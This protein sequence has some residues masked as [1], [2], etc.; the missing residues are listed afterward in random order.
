MRKI[1][2]KIIEDI[3]WICFRFYFDQRDEW[4]RKTT[5]KCFEII[6]KYKLITIK[7][8]GFNNFNEI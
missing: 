4:N 2:E 8:N 1:N 7:P 6:N 3:N 5:H